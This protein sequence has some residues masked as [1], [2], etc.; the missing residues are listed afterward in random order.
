MRKTAISILA[1]GLGPLII[2]QVQAAP[3][4]D[5]GKQAFAVCAACHATTPNTNRVGPTLNRVGGRPIASVARFNY[6]AALKAKRGT[7]TQ[8]SLDAYLKDPRAFAPGNRMAYAG[9]KDAGKRTALVKYLLT[10]K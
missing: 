3:G 10:L 9:M 1:L 8:A 5:A 7:W 4:A 2:A 6:S